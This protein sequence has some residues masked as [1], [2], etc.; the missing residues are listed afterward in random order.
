LTFGAF[1]FDYDLDG[2]LDI[3]CANGH[4]DEEIGRVQPKIAF[5][6][7][8]LLFHNTG[9][10]KFE[11]ATPSQSEVFRH[12]IVARGSA[13]GDFDRDGDLDLLIST[14]NGPA[15]LYRNE[16]GNR[17]NWVSLRLRGTKSNRSGLGAIVRVE[18][19]SGRQAQTVHSGSSYCSQSDLALTFGLGQDKAISSIEIEWPSGK[20]QKLTS[21]ALNKHHVIEEPN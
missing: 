4:I 13:Y 1:F 16:G 17:N 12:A 14:N 18:S 15:Y 21:I 6:Q 3:F 19:T 20:K 9:K 7:A 8:P 11:N 2:W 10:G 5:K